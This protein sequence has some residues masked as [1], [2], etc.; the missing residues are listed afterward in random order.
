[1]DAAEKG[2]R[3]A[4]VFRKAGVLLARSRV[5]RAVEVLKD[6]QA[7]AQEMGDRAMA[8]RFAAEVERALK[9][10]DSSE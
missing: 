4:K 6:G 10:A 5:A 7:L 9:T 1:M 8:Q 2:R 3:Y